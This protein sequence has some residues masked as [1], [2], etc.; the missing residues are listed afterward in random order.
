M[1]GGR[2]A[3][4]PA[5]LFRT[6]EA[7]PQLLR[8]PLPGESALPPHIHKY[9]REQTDPHCSGRSRAGRPAPLAGQG[10]SGGGGGRA[11]DPVSRC[12]SPLKITK[13]DLFF[14]TASGWE[15][16]LTTQNSFTNG[17]VLGFSSLD[18]QI[19]RPEPGLT[20]PRRGRRPAPGRWGPEPAA[21]CRRAEGRGAGSHPR[22]ACRAGESPG[23]PLPPGVCRW[24]RRREP[25]GEPA[26]S[27]GAPRSSRRRLGA[28]LAPSPT[29]QA[30]VENPSG[31]SCFRPGR[32]ARRVCAPSRVPR[33]RGA[34]S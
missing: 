5:R 32:W 12:R 21:G 9:I 19:A 7:G 26:G 1:G 34:R 13:R 27:P 29:S 22:G 15:R 4:W 30:A 11:A 24:G 23:L 3:S 25:R 10:G 28:Q 2:R 20:R 17:L 18:P 6:K 33:G 14:R 16:T 8:V 31:S